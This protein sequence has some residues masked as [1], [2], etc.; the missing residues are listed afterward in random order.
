MYAKPLHPSQLPTETLNNN[1]CLQ[2][3]STSIAFVWFPTLLSPYCRYSYQFS[4]VTN[5]KE[6]RGNCNFSHT[7]S[8]FNCFY[9]R[10]LRNIYF[11]QGWSATLTSFANTEENENV[12]LIRINATRFA[13]NLVTYE[14]ILRLR[15]KNPS[16]FFFTQV[17]SNDIKFKIL[18]GSLPNQFV[19]RL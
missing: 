19:L 2:S 8:K 9:M 15:N 4:L 16:F 3:A 13:E 10:Q 7:P 6:S 17:G 5:T 18:I 11:G 12:P 14:N 1:F